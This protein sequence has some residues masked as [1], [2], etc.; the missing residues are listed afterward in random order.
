[1]LYKASVLLIAAI[2]VLSILPA[3]TASDKNKSDPDHL[4]SAVYIGTGEPNP[5]GKLTDDRIIAWDVASATENSESFA[6]AFYDDMACWTPDWLGA[7][8]GWSEFTGGGGYDW[9][10][11]YW[12]S[13]TCDPDVSDPG[14]DEMIVT[15]PIDLSTYVDAELSFL[16]WNWGFYPGYELAQHYYVLISTVGDTGP[17]DTIVDLA[18]D[19]GDHYYDVVTYDISSYVGGNVWIGFQYIAD[20]AMGNYVQ[21]WEIDDVTVEGEEMQMI[22]DFY[23]S[24]ILNIPDGG[25]I[26]SAPTEIEVL[27]GNAGLVPIG[28]VKKLVD[29]YEKTCGETTTIFDDDMESY[30]PLTEDDNAVWTPIDNGDG[31]TFTLFC[32]EFHSPVQAYRNTLGQYRDPCADDTYLGHAADSGNDELVLDG[33]WN[34][35][36]ASCGRISFWDKCTGEFFDG[37]TGLEAIDFGTIALSFDCGTTWTELPQ[38]DFVAVDN[39]WRDTNIILINESGQF[40][41]TCDGC[42]TQEGDIVINTELYD[43]MDPTVGMVKIKFIWH[44]DPCYQFEGWYIDDVKVTRTENYQLELVFQTHSIQEFGPYEE[45][46]EVF[47]LLFD[48]EPDTWYQIDICGQVFLPIDCEEDFSNNCISKQFKILDIHDVACIGITGPSALEFGDDGVY[49]VTVKNMGTVVENNVPVNLE[50]RTHMFADYVDDDF[51]TD[52]SGV[53]FELLFGDDTAGGSYSWT[54]DYMQ[55]TPQAGFLTN[56]ILTTNEEWDCSAGEPLT[57][58]AQWD[59]GPLGWHGVYYESLISGSAVTLYYSSEVGTASAWHE[60]AWYI[61]DDMDFLDSLGYPYPEYKAILGF[62]YDTDTTGPH[63]GTDPSIPDGYA[64]DNVKFSYDFCVNDPIVVATLYTGVLALGAT[65][66][67]TFT[68]EDATYCDYCVCGN[69]D[70]AGDVDTENDLCCVTTLV[71]AQTELDLEF[72]SEDLTEIDVDTLWQCCCKHTMPDEPEFDCYMWNGMEFDTYAYYLPNTDDSMVTCAY[73]LTAFAGT[74]TN[75]IFDTWY[76]F[77]DSG[78]YGEIYVSPDNGSTWIYIGFVS[79]QANWHFVGYPI[80]PADC[81]DEVRFRFRM[82]SDASGEDDGWYIDD[83]QVGEMHEDCSFAESFESGIPG[84]W[85]LGNNGVDYQDWETTGSSGGGIYGFYPTDGSLMAQLYCFFADPGH[86]AWMITDAIDTTGM[87]VAS[88]TF[89]WLRSEGYSSNDDRMVISASTDGIIFTEIATIHRY[90]TTDHWDIGITVDLTGFLGGNLYLEFRGISEYGE[91][92]HMD[93]LEICEMIFDPI[94]LLEDFEDCEPSCFYFERTPAGD[95]WVYDDYVPLDGYGLIGPRPCGTEGWNIYG[96]GSDQPGL[97]NA[98]YTTVDL[99]ATGSEYIYAIF[100]MYHAWAVEQ[101]S[102]WFIETSADGVNWV[103]EDSFYNP[104]GSGTTYYSDW[105]PITIDLD[106][107]LESVVTIRFRYVTEGNGY[108]VWATGTGWSLASECPMLFYK[109]VIYT[110]ELPPV[111]SLVWDALTATV[112]LFAQDQA[113]PVV[114]GVAATYYEIDGGSTQTYTVPFTL[115]EGSHTVKYWSVDN[116]D[117]IESKKT[118]PTLV[119]DNTDPTCTITEP[120]DGALYLFGSKIMNRILGTTTLCIGKITIVATA[121]DASGINMVLFDV[122]G[123]SGYATSSPYEYIYNDMHF[124]SITVTATAFDNNGNDASDSITFD[125]YSLGIL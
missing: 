18:W 62:R 99:T 69:V 74:G 124:G 98:L 68:W 14:Q 6:V 125:I 45:R 71:T 59:F 116:A 49:E 79:G 110:D 117:N 1:M 88:L 97:N 76:E 26:N 84:A 108:P 38:S 77:E 51:S 46:I 10:E 44:S 86:E 23:I 39:P 96:Y 118:S 73:D 58:D 90:G 50:I 25:F 111:T 87:G 24:D 29:I 19:E 9:Y 3:V 48:P 102:G 91:N 43:A 82:V 31:D 61:K 80:A 63:A 53:W 4:R 121:T 120:E 54:G 93:N 107:Y 40:I 105:E 85:T 81:T 41:D 17:W 67:L 112:S 27:V 92:L 15:P 101:G 66:T 122:D 32:D 33:C 8:C 35:R 83:I 123:D 56:S 109:E 106:G 115:G 2:M 114:S 65:E 113:G 20:W 28:E 21:E 72:E 34:L 30:N 75:L 64:V 52:P 7:P 36:G 55:A 11:K 22:C 119:V 103:V 57:W 5:D 104:P 16:T 13:A 89:D 94:I 100:E 60:E 12:E 47:P 37:P 70:L 42:D 95:Y 78:D